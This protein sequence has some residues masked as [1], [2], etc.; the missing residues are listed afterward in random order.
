MLQRCILDKRIPQALLLTG[1]EGAGT[2]ALAL[3]MA[4][5]VNCHH[6]LTTSTTTEP[7]EACPSCIQSASLQHTNIKLVMALPAGKADSEE[8]VADDV[9][10]AL[11]DVLHA[12]AEDPYTRVRLPNASMI[13][14]GQIREV[15]RMLSLSAAQEGRRVV[16][17]VNAEEMN[18]EASNAF[19]KTLEE[20]HDDVTIILTTSRPERL[21]QTIVSR[22]QE[23]IVPPLS[24]ETVI[25]T[26]VSRG[27][28]SEEE[29]SLVAPFAEGDIQRASD[30][31]SE[32][33]R[34]MRTS[35]L[36]LLRSALRGKDYRNALADAAAEIGDERSKTKAEATLSL[37]AV[38]LRDAY[39]LALGG[40]DVRL[41]NADDRSALE[42]F[43]AAFGSADL[44]A[45]MT[46]IER[47]SRDI[48][49]NT[50]ISLTLLTAMMDI[51]GIIARTRATS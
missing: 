26:L 45:V 42:K 41:V 23:L 24:D 7:C 43:A 34:G 25:N 18:V 33:V 40:P 16:I 9:V 44:P 32:D 17:I 29:A 19:L 48:H 8:D 27:L 38:W 47:A 39:A 1:R 46:V 11:R 22:C 21:L 2:I 6:P 4:R 36:A 28:C 37:L 31:V 10:E 3:A 30:F 14:I 5:T 49:R 13:R 15:K 51:R 50:S 35:A 20:P 12:V